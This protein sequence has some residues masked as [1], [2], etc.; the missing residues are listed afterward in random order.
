[1][2]ADDNSSVIWILVCLIIVTLTGVFLSML[3]EK[4]INF[5]NSHVS[6][7]EEIRIEGKNLIKLKRE[8]DSERDRLTDARESSESFQSNLSNQRSHTQALHGEIESL[9]KRAALLTQT[10]ADTDKNFRTYRETYRATE[11]R[12]AEGEKIENLYLKSGRQFERVIISR[13]TPFGM[14][15]SHAH[16]NARIDFNDLS[17]EYQ[18]RFQ[19]TDDERQEVLEKERRN[20]RLLSGPSEELDKSKTSDPDPED[21]ERLLRAEKRIAISEAGNE[22]RLWRTKV[23][24]LQSS[25]KDALYESRYGTSKSVPGSLK[26]W[27]QQT[28][29]LESEITRANGGLSFAI[30]KLRQLSPSDPLLID[31]SAGR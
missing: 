8:F 14:T 20:R 26:T 11:W 13:I 27:S 29:A 7:A 18:S 12:K 15:I 16:G 24:T 10:I 31:P 22:V 2:F 5:A 21:E 28:R 9:T 1:M 6:F 23:S 25:Y 17:Q 4:R 19:W 30:E 3:V